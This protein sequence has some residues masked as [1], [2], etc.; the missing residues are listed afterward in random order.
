MKK[1]YQKVSVILVVEDTDC[2]LMNDF[3]SEVANITLMQCDIVLIPGPSNEYY[4][5]GKDALILKIKQNDIL[6]L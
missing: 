2:F 1:S 3:N 6:N 5:H 4:I